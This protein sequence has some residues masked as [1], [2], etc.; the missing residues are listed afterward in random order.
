MIRLIWIP[1]LI[2]LYVLSA[3]TSYKNN[4]EGGK[5][6]FFN[7]L[8]ALVPIWQIVSAK[9]NDIFFDAILFDC[10]LILSFTTAL[11]YFSGII[12]NIK[13]I[14]ALLIIFSGLVLFK[15]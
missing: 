1:I 11:G 6:F 10:I 12:L 7:Y 2:I 8:I 4:I 13:Q 5:Y 9:S 3:Y 15:I 14:I